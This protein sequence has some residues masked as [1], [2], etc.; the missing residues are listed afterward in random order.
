MRKL[1]IPATALL[2][3]LLALAPTASAIDKVNT[4]KLRKAVTVDGILE[5]E[6]ALQDIAI[7]N[8]GTRVAVSP[9]QDATV[10]YVVN[11]LK[12]AGYNARKVPFDFPDWTLNG[13]STVEET[14]PTARTFA[15]DTD[16]VEAQ[17]SG[18]GDV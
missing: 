4:N 8:G 9:G 18:A 15:V 7:A 11:R 12:R 13:P 16:F 1:L 6:R 10:A 3:A 2:V 14:S 17:F 5:H